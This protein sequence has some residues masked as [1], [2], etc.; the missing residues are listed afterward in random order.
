MVTATVV[1]VLLALAADQV[2]RLP[3]R[4][5]VAFWV[6]LTV[7]LVPVFPK[8]LPIVEP[9]P[10]PAFIAD[11]MWRPYVAGGRSLVPV[12]L[13][14]VTTGREG[15]RWAGL[16]R[17]E[18]PVPRG[19]F[20]GPANPPENE[21]GSWNAPRRYTSS[22]LQWV[23]TTGTVPL[24]T[25]DQ[26]RR[27]VADL[28]FWRAGV[29]VLVPESRNVSSLSATLTQ[30]LGREPQRAGGVVFWDMRDLPVPPPE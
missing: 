5:R 27:A 4:R 26:R 30:L 11:G 3:H 28:T 21:T 20:M 22:L 12:P 13:P 17:L 19:Y 25:D 6:A 8:P 24:I 7:A 18:F 10:L 15:M 9:L 14:E 16:S 23:S 1:G 29:V 2:P